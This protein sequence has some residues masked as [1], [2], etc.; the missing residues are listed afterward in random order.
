MY[1]S[2]VKQ[3]TTLFENQKYF[4][5]LDEWNLNTTAK[6]PKRWTLLDLLCISKYQEHPIIVGQV[7]KVKFPQLIT[8]VHEM[9][10]DSYAVIEWLFAVKI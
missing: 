1:C 10:Y 7:S 8:Y 3:E 2:A 5:V 4:P 6:V 9:R